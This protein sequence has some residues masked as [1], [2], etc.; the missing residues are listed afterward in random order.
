MRLHSGDSTIVDVPRYE[1]NL[2]EEADNPPEVKRLMAEIGKA[3]SSSLSYPSL[4]SKIAGPE[5]AI[6]CNRPFVYNTIPLVL[7]HEAFGIFKDK[8]E[9]PPSDQH[10]PVL[11]N[12]PFW[13]ANGTSRR[14]TGEQRSCTCSTITSAL[15]F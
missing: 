7:L 2:N 6:G 14:P 9:T 15:R 1:H 12:S 3:P 8:C 13:Y 10:S 11:T 4:F 5:H